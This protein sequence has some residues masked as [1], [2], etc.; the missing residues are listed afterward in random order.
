M[1]CC[2]VSVVQWCPTRKLLANAILT[3]SNLTT[4]L[5][6]PGN[7][8]CE[9]INETLNNMFICRA[10]RPRIQGIFIKAMDEAFDPRLCLSDHSR[11]E[12]LLLF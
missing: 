10:R 6:S 3:Q 11:A 1:V 7:F 12:L 9:L 5:S 4:V 8:N 2:D